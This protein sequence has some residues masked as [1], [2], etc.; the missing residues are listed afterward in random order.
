MGDMPFAL[1]GPDMY[2]VLLHLVC[3]HTD[4]SH[5]QNSATAFTFMY[6]MTSAG[7]Q[8]HTQCSTGHTSDI[9]CAYMESLE[10]FG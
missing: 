7:V 5:L 6:T 10:M 3:Q 4:T 9:G 1:Y 2:Q 8:S